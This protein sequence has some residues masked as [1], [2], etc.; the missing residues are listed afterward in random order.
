MSLIP[1]APFI[2]PP[3]A[4]SRHLPYLP[5]VWERSRT[6]Q[7]KIVNDPHLLSATRSTFGG[8]EVMINKNDRLMAESEIATAL[9]TLLVS[10]YIVTDVTR[11]SERSAILSA[12]KRDKLGGLA[13]STILFA[14]KPAPNVIEMLRKT[15]VQNGSSPL[16]VTT[17]TVTGVSTIQP[18]QFYDLLGGEIRFDRLMRDDLPAIVDALGHNR[19]PNELKN[20][21]PEDLLEDYVK[22]GLEF[23]LQ[24]RGWRYGQERL[25]ESVPDGIVLGRLNLY[26][27]GKAYKGGY[28]PSA[29]D[30]K[31]FAGYVNEFNERYSTSVG[32]IHSFVVVSGSFT[33]KQNALEK[34]AADFYARCST[35]LCYITA[36]DFGQIVT[37]VRLKCANRSAIKWANVFS[38]IRI[39]PMSV[40]SELRRIAKDRIID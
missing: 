13:T 17:A 2:L 6:A 39:E 5:A 35:Q 22:E 12:R 27:D 20:G 10:G 24:S 11:I 33:A 23:L 40:A 28:H 8:L 34:K 9:R 31:R 14:E 3:S 19:L 16:I 25:F 7:T 37:D 1:F 32:R 30:I 21:N 36:V 38:Q 18:R 4:F 29:D 15:A 26:F